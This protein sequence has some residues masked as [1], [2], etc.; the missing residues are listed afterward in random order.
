MI[1]RYGGEEFMLILT[2][3]GVD[4]GAILTEKLRASVQRQRYPSAVGSRSR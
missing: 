1:G 2:E 3:T 4:E